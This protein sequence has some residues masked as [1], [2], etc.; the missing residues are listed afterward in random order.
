M[1][2]ARRAAASATFA[3]FYVEEAHATDEWPIRSSKAAAPGRSGIPVEYA[4]AKSLSDRLAAASDLVAHFGLAA[5][6]IAVYA[7]AL[8]DPPLR[9]PFQHVYAAW[10]IRWYIFLGGRVMRIGEPDDGRFDLGYIGA[11]LGELGVVL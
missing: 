4:Q 6:P 8:D 1:A 9:N 5:A 11:A 7:D 10:P 2:L 3:L